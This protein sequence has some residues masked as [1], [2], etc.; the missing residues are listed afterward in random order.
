MIE[1]LKELAGWRRGIAAT[2]RELEQKKQRRDY[3][4]TAPLSLAEALAVELEHVDL[5]EKLFR[6]NLL[7][8]AIYTFTSNPWETAKDPR[9][10]NAPQFPV[11][12]HRHGL[13]TH[14]DPRV[15]IGALAPQVREAIK[16]AFAEQTDWPAEC[17]PRLADR[18]AERDVLDL[19]IATLEAELGEA[20]TLAAQQGLTL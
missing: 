15:L 9:S 3:L 7:S 6:E 18:I 14:A 8:H 5:C 13:T 16:A 11:V 12:S 2:K 4:K 19:R 1:W 20:K 17:G 10:V